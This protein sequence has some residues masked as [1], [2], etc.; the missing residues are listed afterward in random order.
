MW[1]QNRRM[2]WRHMKESENVSLTNPESQKESI[3]KLVK[4]NAKSASSEKAGPEYEEEIEIEV[5]V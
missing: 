3:R 5:D 4:D 1:F 2:K